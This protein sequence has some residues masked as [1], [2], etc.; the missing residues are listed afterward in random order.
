[1]KLLSRTNLSFILNLFR[2]VILIKD[3]N[4]QEIAGHKL[5]M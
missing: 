2:T 3:M 4:T 1:M 5:K